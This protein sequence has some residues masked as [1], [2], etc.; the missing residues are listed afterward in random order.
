MTPD[1]YSSPVE[2]FPLPFEV[3]YDLKCAL[4]FLFLLISGN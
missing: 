3:Q 2:C 1:I 4:F